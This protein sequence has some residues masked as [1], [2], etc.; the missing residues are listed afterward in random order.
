MTVWMM[1]LSASSLPGELRPRLVTCHSI[2]AEKYIKKKSISRHFSSE[3][4]L[5]EDV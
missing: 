1:P 5:S 3:Q 4:A 2:S